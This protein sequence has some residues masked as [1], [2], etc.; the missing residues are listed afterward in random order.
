MK[1]VLIKNLENRLFSRYNN[2]GIV[3]RSS[4]KFL[5]I[6]ASIFFL[7]M[8]ATFI[9]FVGRVEF[10]RLAVSCLTSI[11][12]AVI[13]VI[14]I[15]YGKLSSAAS[16]FVIFQ[17]CISIAGAHA[18][19][20]DIVLIT[21]TYFLYPML[22]MAAMF[23]PRIIQTIVLILISGLLIWN[24]Y[25]YNPSSI[26]ND[27]SV[28][29]G[30]IRLGTIM[31]LVSIFLTYT[32]TY[33][34]MRFL[35]LAISA[36]ENEAKITAEK[37]EYITHLIETIRTS[38]HELTTSI[39]STEE[40]ITDIFVNTQTQAATIEELAASMEQISANTANVDT[41]TID[42]N[43]SV[44]E[45]SGS[46]HSLYKL[47]TQLQVYGT[48]LQD[49]FAVIT[50]TALSG[51]K[52]SQ[53]INEIN[54]KIVLNSINMQSIADIIDDF[55]DRIN[56][57]ALN[58]AIEAA[59][60][61][62]HGRGF[63]VVADEVSKLADNSSSELNKIK[64]LISNNRK[65]MESAGVIVEEIVN[66]I[67]GIGVSLVSAEKKATD[68]LNIISQQNIIQHE[69]LDK[70]GSVQEKSGIIKNASSEQSSAIN[71]IVVSI[72]NTSSIVQ[73]IAGHAQVLK[74]NYEKL[75]SL[76]VKLNVIISDD[77]CGGVT[78]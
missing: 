69:M 3:E 64:S 4:A 51:K 24:N 74:T 6:I 78:A 61:G 13:T 10:V 72:D 68:T 11:S 67:E 60:A 19:T 77:T 9:I 1:M 2:R 43:E 31:G 75:K 59:R 12:S 15:R 54:K 41:A 49:E 30:F 21:I 27:T 76:A 52:S 37:N 57:L 42:Q 63:G 23:A 17:C 36:S 29:A 53:S 55:F 58:A 33:F 50:A 44:T 65:D 14:L 25:R 34:V 45:L 8:T 39:D 70:T 38:Y 22:V 66:F 47:I 46:I 71:E 32:I 7:L 18:R 56:L 73:N 62:E 5:F 28:N 26:N 48:D 16:C 35:K 20:P 40:V